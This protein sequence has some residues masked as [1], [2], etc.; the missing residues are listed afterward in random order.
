MMYSPLAF[1]REAVELNDKRMRLNTK[2][3]RAF[4]KIAE[5]SQ[6]GVIQPAICIF[7]NKPLNDAPELS[8]AATL[9]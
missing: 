2:K 3:E 7:S 1:R 6:P 9:Y 4:A 8:A 5:I